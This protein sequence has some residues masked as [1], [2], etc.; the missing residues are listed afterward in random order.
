M[1]KGRPPR[2]TKIQVDLR[3]D[4]SKRRRNTSEPEAP[5]GWPECPDHIKADE[6]AAAEWQSVC[7]HLE[8]LG[9][10]SPVDV[11]ILALY[12]KTWARYLRAE[13]N[14]DKYGEVFISKN[15][16]TPML[17]TFYTARN[18]YAEDLRKYLVELGLSPSARAR[19][20]ISADDK[21][22][23]GWSGLLRVA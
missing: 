7:K 5:A 9:I 14:L 3:G 11:S 13:E 23:D 8:T 12:C 6:Y 15:R 1:A 17:S 20:R 19:M 18:R 2:P 4:P 21:P 16:Q 10:L 22:D